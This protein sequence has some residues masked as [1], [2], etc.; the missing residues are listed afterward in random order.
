MCKT[1]YSGLA[2]KVKNILNFLLKK[3]YR[4]IYGP[5]KKRLKKNHR[6]FCGLNV[7]KHNLILL[8][9]MMPYESSRLEFLKSYTSYKTS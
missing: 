7:G 8:M 5:L 3:L 1:I 4:V 6:L 2:S 9:D